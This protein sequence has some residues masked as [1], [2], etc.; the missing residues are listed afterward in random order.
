MENKVNSLMGVSIDKI[1]E[2]VDINMV[3][4]DPM[5]LA[6]GTTL[7]P[8][9]KVTYGFATGGSDLPSK[10]TQELFGGG[11]GAGINIVPIAFLVVSKGDVRLLPLVS[12]PDTLNQVVNMI[13]D[14]V[15]KIGDLFTKGK[16]VK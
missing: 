16:E 10:G 9:S 3:V 11:G 1:R 7:I 12:T 6:D 13:P 5:T 15:N 8:V 4:G 2:M 14:T